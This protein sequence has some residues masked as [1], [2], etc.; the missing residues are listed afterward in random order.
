[1]SRNTFVEG[2]PPYADESRRP[3]QSESERSKERELMKV[4]KKLHD[5]WRNGNMSA[6]QAGS[7]LL[8]EVRRILYPA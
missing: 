6:D 1:M 2:L 5:Q 4:A 8:C 7:E 3:D